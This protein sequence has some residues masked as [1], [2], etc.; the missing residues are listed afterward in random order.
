MIHVFDLLGIDE[1]E[2]LSFWIDC[3]IHTSSLPEEDKCEA[4]RL[5]V[6]D[7]PEEITEMLIRY[8]IVHQLNPVTEAG[9]YNMRDLRRYLDDKLSR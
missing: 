1:P 5:N 4:E 2:D 8:L 9:S 7:T 3:M 6:R